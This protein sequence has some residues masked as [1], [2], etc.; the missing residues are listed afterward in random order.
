MRFTS[1]VY[2]QLVVHDLGVTFV[3]GE[4]EVT[5]KATADLL[6]GL[7]AELGVRAVGGRPP[8]ESTNES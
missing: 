5:D 6:R 3:D 1:S 4:A 8:R 2:K 7:P